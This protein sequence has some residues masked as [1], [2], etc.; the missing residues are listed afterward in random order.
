MAIKISGTT[1]INNSRALENVINL[2]GTYNDFFPNSSTITTELDLSKPL[3]TLTMSSN[4]T[5]TATGFLGGRTST[6][7]LDTSASAHTPTFPASIEFSPGTPTWSGSRY[8]TISF[9]AISGSAARAFA[10]GYSA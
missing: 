2:S 4:T 5:F 10:V 7:V 1:V 9:L 6:L 3:M 8:W